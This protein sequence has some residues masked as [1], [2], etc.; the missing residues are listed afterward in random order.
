MKE[1]EQRAAIL[2]HDLEQE[3]LKKQQEEIQK[4]RNQRNFRSNPIKHYKPIVLKPSDKSLTAPKSPQLS[5]STMRSNDTSR[6]AQ[7]NTENFANSHRLSMALVDA[8]LIKKYS[9]NN[10]NNNRSK[11]ESENRMQAK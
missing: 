7:D 1:K 4:I 6:N 2:K 3:K 9:V 8:P 10:K 5:T 11:C